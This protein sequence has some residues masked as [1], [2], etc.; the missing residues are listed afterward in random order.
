MLPKF[1]FH[2]HSRY[3]DGT[4]EPT[5]MVEAA[6]AKKMKAVAVTDHG[7]ELVVGIYR[8]DIESMLKDVELVKKDSDILVLSG[9][10]AN[11]LDRTGA[12]DI[13]EN[14]TG[15]LDILLGGVHRMDPFTRGVHN[16][17]A[18]YLE[19]VN[20][21]MRSGKIDILAHPFQFYGDLS[22]HL[23]PENIREFAQTAAENNV[24]IE[25]NSKY[26][27]PPLEILNACM[28]EGV[29]FSI[30][31]DSHRPESVGTINWQLKTLKEIG[32]KKEDLILE[33]FL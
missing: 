25:L 9:M 12:I 32:A 2:I 30:G 4:R 20:N 22:A 8:E 3:S 23:S 33:R 18:L 14:V 19:T 17:S 11:I 27:C 16:L 29:K 28:K 6:E 1:D 24:A 31:T 15:K 13:D 5:T 21:T 26:A 7:P 10:E